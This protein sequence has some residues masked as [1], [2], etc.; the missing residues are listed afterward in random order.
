MSSVSLAINQLTD[1]LAVSSLWDDAALRRSVL[2]EALPGL[3][4]QLVGGLDVLMK[5]VPENYLRAVFSSFLASS[6]VYKHGFGTSQMA[7]FQYM[8]NRIEKK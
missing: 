5:R 7:F 8:Q 2:S 6:F 1:E 4:Q 3:L